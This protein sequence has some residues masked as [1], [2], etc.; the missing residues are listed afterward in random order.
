MPSMQI[1]GRSWVFTINNFTSVDLDNISRLDY[2]YIIYGFERGESGTPHLQGF[3][4]FKNARSRQ[5]LSQKLPRAFLDK[6]RGTVDQAIA[7]CKKDG[8]FI[9]KGTK[10]IDQEE[11]LQLGRN[12][13]NEA[14]RTIISKAENGDFEWIKSNYPAVWI[15]RMP[16]LRSMHKPT[17]KILDGDL[18]HEWWHGPTG[19]GK[20]STVWRLYPIHYQKQLNK[21]WDGYDNEL[22]VVIEEWAPKN[23]VSG[24][25]LKI[26][27]D[28]Y[29]FPAQIKG[30]TLQRTRPQ[31]IIVLS[32]Y[33]IAECFTDSQDREPILRRFTQ[34]RFPEDIAMTTTRAQS[35]HELHPTASTNIESPAQSPP[36][37]PT[38]VHLERPRH[39][40]DYDDD[41]GGDNRLSTNVLDD[42]DVL[43]Y[44]DSLIQ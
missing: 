44:L 25:Q 17:A 26:W 27:A 23:E 41:V 10:P 40:L 9:E 37:T 39:S 34:I 12:K 29:P 42:E 32:N 19:C 8:V 43:T 1:R 24:S 5:S 20:S 28:R 4:H 36:R 30:G 33:S 13:A 2:Q 11:A 22:V 38:G 21:W 31:K 16:S 15:A 35:F 3:V 18:Q 14:N 7:Y 6:R